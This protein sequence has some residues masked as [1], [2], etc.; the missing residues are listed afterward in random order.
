[1]ILADGQVTREEVDQL[2]TVA[3]TLRRVLALLVMVETIQR[4]GLTFIRTGRL[5][6]DV[7]RDHPEFG[8]AG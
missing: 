3:A 7:L 1:V 6:R 5:P 4:A 2:S 8:K